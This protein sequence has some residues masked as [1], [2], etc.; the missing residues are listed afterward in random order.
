MRR[1][2]PTSGAHLHR[3]QLIKGC[4]FVLKLREVFDK[5]C[6]KYAMCIRQFTAEFVHGMRMPERCREFQLA[7]ISSIDNYCTHIREKQ[8]GFLI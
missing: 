4:F 2:T 5:E 3:V 1:K 8:N 7:E 6:R